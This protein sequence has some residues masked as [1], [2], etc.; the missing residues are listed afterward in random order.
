MTGEKFIL[1][2]AEVSPGGTTSTK[3]RLS[4]NRELFFSQNMMGEKFI[5]S[6][7]EVSPG[8]TTSTKTRLHSGL[9]VEAFFIC[10]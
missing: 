3:T 5:L 2:A 4:R 6:A 9:P 8:G 7:A 1:S 10:T